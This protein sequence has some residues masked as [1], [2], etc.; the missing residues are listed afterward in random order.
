[1]NQELASEMMMLS[2]RS[3]WEDRCWSSYRQKWR[4]IIV[5]N[6]ALIMS[7]RVSD[8]WPFFLSCFKGLARVYH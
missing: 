8:T 6:H 4:A 2:Y 5:V 1:M 3:G 7:L